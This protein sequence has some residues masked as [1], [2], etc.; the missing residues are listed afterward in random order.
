MTPAPMQE[1]VARIRELVRSG[2]FA[3]ALQTFR[4]SGDA[5]RRPDG[6][7]LE[8]RAE[9][10]VQPGGEYERHEIGRAHV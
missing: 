2:R 7:Q 9:G 6:L 5:A 1:P 4:E 8:R 10:Q 3:D